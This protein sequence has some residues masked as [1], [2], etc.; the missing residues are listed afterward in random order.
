MNIFFIWNLNSNM[1][2]T[3]RS[4]QCCGVEHGN[5]AEKHL[6]HPAAHPV[7][8]HLAGALTNLSQ[9]NSY[10]KSK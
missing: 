7:T 4:L 5:K 3:L 6:Q 2:N 1:I 8:V 9:H 10:F